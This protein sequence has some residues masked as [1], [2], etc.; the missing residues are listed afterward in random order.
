MIETQRLFFAIPLP[1][2]VKEEMSRVQVKLRGQLSDQQV[3][4]VRP[5]TSH[6][7]L[8]FLGDV[9][10]HRIQPLIERIEQ[11]RFL[12]PFELQLTDIGAFPSVR[13]PKVLILRT[14]MHAPLHALREG[15]ADVIH[16]CGF[17]VDERKFQPHITLG[18]FQSLV[19]ALEV[20]EVNVKPISFTVDQVNLYQSTLTPTGSIYTPI[21]TIHLT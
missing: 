11:E 7:T 18:R 2:H 6:V 8:H 10:V 1:E 14:S 5:R 3:S 12:D 13:K 17:D 19:G 16:T 4:W 9:E 21:H 20:G 15:I